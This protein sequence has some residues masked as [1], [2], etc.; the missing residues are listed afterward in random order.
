MNEVE[1]SLYLTFLDLST[2]QKGYLL[3]PEIYDVLFKLLKSDEEKATGDVQVLCQLFS[4]EATSY[5]YTT[6]NVSKIAQN[7]PFC[8][9]GSTQVPFA[10]RLVT[11]LAQGHGLLDRF[12]V[13]FPK[14]LRPTPLQ[15]KPSPGVPSTK[16]DQKLQ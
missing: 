12:L 5:T 16:T 1:Y 15:T 10:A 7:T 9:L 13:T 2:N 14:C 8:V 11:L 6:E 4:G 3:S